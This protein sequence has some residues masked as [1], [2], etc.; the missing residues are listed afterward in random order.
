VSMTWRAITVRPVTLAVGVACEGTKIIAGES[1]LA[2]RTDF[3]SQ[4][5]CADSSP[6][7]RFALHLGFLHLLLVVLVAEHHLL[8][9]ADGQRE[10]G[11][12]A[13]LVVAATVEFESKGRNQFI[14]C[15]KR[16]NQ[17]LIRQV[18]SP[19]RLHRLTIF[20]SAAEAP[21][22]SARQMRMPSSHPSSRSRLSS[23]PMG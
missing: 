20:K 15:F 8:R 19:F 9:G 7:R 23:S 2:Y 1:S 13:G 18:S 4:E 14:T 17:A 3:M 11:V 5:N 16:W 22:S 21:A 6:M 10:R 12:R